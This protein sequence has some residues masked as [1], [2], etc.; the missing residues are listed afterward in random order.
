[1]RHKGELVG[2]DLWKEGSVTIGIPNLAVNAAG[3]FLRTAGPALI[4]PDVVDSS[5]WKKGKL[6]FMDPDRLNHVFSV[7]H[8]NFISKNLEG[9][10]RLFSYWF[11]LIIEN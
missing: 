8:W 1:M 3:R 11:L 10:T 4:L 2:E 9:Q 6:W 5:R 7:D